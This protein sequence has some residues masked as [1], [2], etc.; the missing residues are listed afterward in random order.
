MQV[1]SDVLRNAKVDLD[2]D[3]IAFLA[4]QVRAEL[5]RI[6]NNEKQ[7]LLMVMAQEKAHR[8]EFSDARIVQFLRC[9]AMHPKVRLCINDAAPAAL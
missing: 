1:L 5:N 4:R 3:S 7:A 8:E 6:P 9:E 2:A